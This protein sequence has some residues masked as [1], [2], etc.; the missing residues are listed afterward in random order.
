MS[1]LPGQVRNKRWIKVDVCGIRARGALPCHLTTM[2]P[3]MWISGS[4][5][6]PS[7]VRWWWKR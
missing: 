1:C 3:S 2:I 4:G 7:A 6:W 5:T